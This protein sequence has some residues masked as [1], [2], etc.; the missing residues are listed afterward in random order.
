VPG[1][2]LRAQNYVIFSFQEISHVVFLVARHS[3]E[4]G[5][6]KK[7]RAERHLSKRSSCL[8]LK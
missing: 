2:F 8:V 5:G 4:Q 7:T 6:S 3:A 1:I